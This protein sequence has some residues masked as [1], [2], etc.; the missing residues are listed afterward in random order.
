MGAGLGLAACASTPEATVARPIGDEL[1]LA[2]AAGAYPIDPQTTKVRF[3]A[4]PTPAGTVNGNFTTFT[5]ELTVDDAVAGAAG[6]RATLDVGSLDVNG[7][8]FR[9]TILGPGWF[10]AMMFPEAGF[11]G[12]LLGWNPDGTGDLVGQMTIRDVTREE[13]FRLVLTCDG[14]EACP[15]RQVGFEGAA[16]LDRTAYGMTRLAGLVG[17]EVQITVS[18]VL[19]VEDGDGIR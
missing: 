12:R 17:K 18:G 1:R 2:I 4:G 5:G 14:I 6:L 16:S 3:L 9:S 8:F 10:E 11:E 13:T 7:N 19:M 15:E